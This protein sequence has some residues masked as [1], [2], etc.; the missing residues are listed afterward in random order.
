MVVSEYLICVLLTYPC[1]HRVSIYNFG[2]DTT[3]AKIM[4]RPN[5]K[6]LE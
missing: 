5:I 4:T 2:G 6:V 3:G 1:H